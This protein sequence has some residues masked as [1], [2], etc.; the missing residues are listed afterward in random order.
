MGRKNF[1]PAEAIGLVTLS[2]TEIVAAKGSLKLAGDTALGNED[3]GLAL[4]RF[5]EA[6]FRCVLPALPSA[7]VLESERLEAIAEVLEVLTLAKPSAGRSKAKFNET[8]RLRN[9]PK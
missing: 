5:D 1:I 3:Q 7:S 6:A 9:T 4:F 2:D 8:S